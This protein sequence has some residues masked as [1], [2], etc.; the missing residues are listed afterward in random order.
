MDPQ[1]KDYWRRKICWKWALAAL[2]LGTFLAAAVA[3]ARVAPRTTVAYLYVGAQ[4]PLAM[5]H[6]ALMRCI[7][8]S[9]AGGGDE[10]SAFV[11]ACAGEMCYLTVNK[12]LAD[13]IGK[14]AC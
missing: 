13:L 8:Q 6:N 3:V 14:H 4:W 10:W 1:M 2:V 7:G 12:M 5:Q 11:L 9:E